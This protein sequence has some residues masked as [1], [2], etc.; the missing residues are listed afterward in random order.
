MWFTKQPQS[1]DRAWIG[2]KAQ[3]SSSADGLGTIE[4][5]WLKSST[6]EGNF[7]PLTK[8][9]D[10]TGVLYFNRL[11]Q[12]D[13]GYYQCQAQNDKEFVTSETVY[14]RPTIPSVKRANCE[15]TT[16]FVVAAES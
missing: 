5:T 1:I 11:Q 12:R 10:R 3:L 15:C 4:Y 8:K 2:E 16:S 6:K 9:F 7:V 13:W 14:V